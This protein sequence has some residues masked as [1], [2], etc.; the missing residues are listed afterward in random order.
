[1]SDQKIRK[2]ARIYP[3]NE[4]HSDNLF[5]TCGSFEERF[6][7]VLRKISGNFPDEIILF[8]FIHPNEKRVELIKKMEEIL[9]TN[10]F[11]DRYRIIDTIHGKGIESIIEFH[12]I[13]SK[14]RNKNLFITIDISTFTKDLL[15]NLM[16]YLKYFL[17]V[18]KL[19]LFYTL[20]KRY[21]SPQEGWLSYGIKSIHFPPLFWNSW[22]PLKDNLLIVILGFEELRAWSLIYNFSCDKKML[23]ITS[24]GS[25]KEWD[26][27]CRE[28]N[29][30]LLKE[31]PAKD[32]LPAL[33]PAGTVEKL[34]KHINNDLAKKYN[35]FI[36]PLGPK[37]QLIG[38]LNY[39]MDNPNIPINLVTTTVVNHNIPYYSWGVGDTFEFFFR[40]R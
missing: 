28:Y 35:I 40:V 5:I 32:N 7:G 38:M 2:V 10:R 14:R 34:S 22:S 9:N 36:S 15:V 26:V 39:C 29:K 30:R 6:L 4:D 31:I 3:I 13:M 8:R 37:P 27:Y 23:F 19:R 17:K 16:V 11:G 12:N 24:P 1:M 21:A 18:K 20:P 33:D 25:K